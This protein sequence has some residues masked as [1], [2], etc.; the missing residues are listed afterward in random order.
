MTRNDVER[1]VS[2]SIDLHSSNDV[3]S[4]SELKKILTDVLYEFGASSALSDSVEK[5]I[6]QKQKLNRN[7]QGLR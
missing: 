7:L 6:S 4:K 1:I 2:R 5:K 3:V